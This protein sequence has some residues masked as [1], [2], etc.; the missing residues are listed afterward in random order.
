MTVNGRAGLVRDP[1]SKKNGVPKK[2]HVIF[3]VDVEAII[4]HLG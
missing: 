4:E 1:H 2:Q 3:M